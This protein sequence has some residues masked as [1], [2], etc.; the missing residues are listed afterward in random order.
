MV[1]TINKNILSIN[2]EATDD[3][4]TEYVM[5]LKELGI[6]FILFIK[7]SSNK[8]LNDIRMKFFDCGVVEKINTIFLADL[9]KECKIYLN[10][11]DF[12]LD[13]NK[14]IIK[15]NKVIFANNQIYL[16]KQHF[17]IDQPSKLG[18]KAGAI[19]HE[20]FLEDYEHF[21]FLLKN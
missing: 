1:K 15:S 9:E 12:I 10:K 13:I 2:I 16:S 19:D 21:Y 20:L 6:K 5:R 8:N 3:I 7:D 14:V 11:K 4:S 17:L 18:A